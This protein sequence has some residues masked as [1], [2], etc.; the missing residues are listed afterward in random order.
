MSKTNKSVLPTDNSVLPKKEKS[1]FTKFLELVYRSDVQN[2]IVGVIVFNSIVLGL[3]TSETVTNRIGGLLK[4]L[5]TLCLVIFCIELLMKIIYEKLSFFKS[6]WNI[7]DFV[8]VGISLVPGSGK[9]SVLRSL[10]ILRSMRLITKLPRLRVIVEAII[11]SLPSICWISLL[12]VVIFYIFSVLT[13]TLFGKAFPDW[14]GSI[15]ASMYTLFQML[16]LESWSMGIA[17]P[18]MQTFPYAYIIFIPFILISSFIVL[19]VFIGVIVNT[20]GEVTLE[21][22]KPD[23]TPEGEDDLSETTEQE[24]KAVLVKAPDHLA[25]VGIEISL[26][27]HQLDRIEKMLESERG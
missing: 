19:N 12:L 25:A 8:I 9:L 11:R 22:P 14:F 17:R 18:V 2:F 6:A 1:A 24:E 15:G 5:D 23:L 10:R 27:K 3:E 13:T 16:T 26:I 20:I 4:F 21:A 7:F